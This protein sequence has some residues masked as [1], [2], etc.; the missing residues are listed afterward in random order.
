MLTGIFFPFPF[1]NRSMKLTSSIMPASKLHAITNT[2]TISLKIAE[3]TTRTESF[4]MRTCS[5]LTETEYAFS[6]SLLKQE[7]PFSTDKRSCT[8]LDKGHAKWL[9]EHYAD[10]VV[11]SDNTGNNTYITLYEGIYINPVQRIT[12]NSCNHNLGK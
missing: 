7:H 3:L 5:V 1:R 12:K 11:H 4:S 2:S 6:I 8:R 9:K 10:R